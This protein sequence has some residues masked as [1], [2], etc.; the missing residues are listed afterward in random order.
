[1]HKIFPVLC[2]VFL[3]CRFCYV[4]CVSL[5]AFLHIKIIFVSCNGFQTKK[6][7]SNQ[8][9]KKAFFGVCLSEEEAD[10]GK[11]SWAGK[12]WG[13]R[14]FHTTG[15]WN[16]D[17]VGSD[18]WWDSGALPCV[19]VGGLSPNHKPVSLGTLAY[20]RPISEFLSSSSS[21]QSCSLSLLGSHWVS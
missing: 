8:N 21:P 14:L 5:K 3:P 11:C 10:A 15:K 2:D 9:F 17:T 13:E 6:E 7:K 20:V 12:I 4:L 18:G 16:K 19:P 1:M